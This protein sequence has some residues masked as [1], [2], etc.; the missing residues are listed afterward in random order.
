M[1]LVVSY[2]LGLLCGPAL[3]HISALSVVVGL[4]PK[5]KFCSSSWRLQTDGA[6]RYRAC[7]IGRSRSGGIHPA[8]WEVLGVTIY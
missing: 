6:F 1:L 4:N 7:V 8:S 2:Y 3:Y 5:S